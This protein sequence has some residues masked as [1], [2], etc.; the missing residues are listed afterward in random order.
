VLYTAYIG[1]LDSLFGVM[2][3]WLYSTK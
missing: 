2:S 3:N 1:G